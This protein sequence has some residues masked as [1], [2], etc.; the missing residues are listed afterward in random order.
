P[1]PPLVCWVKPTLQL[2]TRIQLIFSSNSFRPLNN[3]AVLV[4][5]F[6]AW[7]N[8]RSA[9]NP[10]LFT[11]QALKEFN[12]LKKAFTTAPILA[13]FSIISQYFS[14]NL[15]HPAQW[16]EFLSEFHFT[17]TYGPGKLVV[18]LDALSRQ[19]NVYPREGKDIANINP[20]NVR[21]IF[22][23]LTHSDSPKRY[24]KQHNFT[25]EPEV[26]HSPIKTRLPS[27]WSF[28]TRKDL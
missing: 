11:K 20:D 23:P 28:W 24:L 12:A 27:G 21:T 3:P 22:S 2:K 25:F 1:N 5:S 18:V 7:E 10:F 13:H 15:L 26:I 19:D 17:I 8:S 14:S 6:A 16:A 4:Q 9:N